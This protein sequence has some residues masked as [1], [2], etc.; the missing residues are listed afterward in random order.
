LLERAR[1]ALVERRAHVQAQKAQHQKSLLKSLDSGPKSA[2]AT[3]AGLGYLVS[4]G[5]RTKALK[6]GR[7][8]LALTLA[9]DGEVAKELS[10]K[11]G[12]SRGSSTPDQVPLNHTFV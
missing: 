1:V 12:S 8:H 7:I 6:K 4:D 10:H 5:E 9:A 3:N 2:I 11:R